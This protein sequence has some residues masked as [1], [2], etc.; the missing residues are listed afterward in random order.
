MQ[1]SCHSPSGVQ[2]ACLLIP[3]DVPLVIWHMGSAFLR[4][5]LVNM[6]FLCLTL[7]YLF[8]QDLITNVICCRFSLI[9]W[10]SLI[11]LF[12]YSCLI[13]LFLSVMTECLFFSEHSVKIHLILCYTSLKI[14]W[15][16]IWLSVIFHLNF[17]ELSLNSFIIQAI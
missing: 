15:L 5:T 3:S 13:C 11:M 7:M 6:I 9:S 12:V 17:N 14:Q 2:G 16:F 8:A 10:R 4:K 1:L